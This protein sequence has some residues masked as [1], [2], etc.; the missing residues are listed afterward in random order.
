MQGAAAMQ[1]S[2]AMLLK[3]VGSAPNVSTYSWHKGNGV[4]CL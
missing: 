3:A 4:C 1:H 2:E